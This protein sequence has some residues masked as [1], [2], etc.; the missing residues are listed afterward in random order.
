MK[1]FDLQAAKNGAPICTRD[2]RPARFLGSLNDQQNT[3]AVAVKLTS[4]EE[5]LMQY[6]S[7]GEFDK[8][9]TDEN[10]LCM[11]EGLPTVVT[12]YI[13]VFHYHNKVF[14]GQH[15][16]ESEFAAVQHGKIANNYVTTVFVTSQFKE[17]IA[18]ETIEELY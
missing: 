5:I 4:G 2:G 11:Y 15:I 13:N 8:Y 16:Y 18:D 14:C 10:D 3:I 7:T 17:P 12:G 1:K 9:S 6:Y